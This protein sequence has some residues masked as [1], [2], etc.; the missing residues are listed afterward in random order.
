MNGSSAPPEERT[1]RGAGPRSLTH[2]PVRTNA[3]RFQIVL[4]LKT[5]N[6]RIEV[7]VCLSIID[8][9]PGGHAL[10]N[11]GTRVFVSFRRLG[12]TEN[13]VW[14]V[15]YLFLSLVLF[16]DKERNNDVG[17]AGDTL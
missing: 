5:D 13:Q 12:R 8:K 10:V 3:P 4:V 11:F 2:P 7:L 16:G 17:S 6:F 9:V 14:A 1:A 15:P